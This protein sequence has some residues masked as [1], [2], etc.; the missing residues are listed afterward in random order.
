MAISKRSA[1]SFA[2]PAAAVKTN[3]NAIPTPF[4]NAPAALQ[5]LLPQLDPARVHL[6]HI[7]RH[8]P[9]HKKQIVRSLPPKITPSN[10][11]PP[12]KLTP[13]PVHHPPPPQHP[14]CPRPRLPRLHR[15]ALLLQPPP[16]PHRR[17]FQ[18]HNSQPQH[19]TAAR[20]S[21]SHPAALRNV[22]LRLHPHPLPRSLALG[23]LLRAAL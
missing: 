11:N 12:P 22:P 1:K 19:N 6:I 16:D 5:P 18:P 23:F 8:S 13:H 3:S 10:P 15:S 17:R 20:S 9:E 2:K 21:Q 14:R 4:T 7:D